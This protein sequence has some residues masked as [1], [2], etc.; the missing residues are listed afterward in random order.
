MFL[1]SA[2]YAA[3]NSN[4]VVSDSVVVGFVHDF[5]KE[6]QTKSEV[7]KQETYMTMLWA[8]ILL[9][10]ICIVLSL[11][12]GRNIHRR[13]KVERENNELSRQ[14]T[15]LSDSYYENIKIST[16]QGMHLFNSLMQTYYQGQPERI[17]PTLE[18]IMNNLVSDEKVITQF[19]E[20]INKTR[21]NLISRLTVS[22]PNLS[23]KEILLYIYLAVQL[24]HNAICLILDKSPGALNAQIY[25]MR[26]KIEDS[27]SPWKEEFLDAI[28]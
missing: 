14:L 19:M 18:S 13:K 20:T 26:R 11:L 23:Q 3:D 9:I 2:Y 24:N 1:F 8:F 27:E 5:R 6:L 28:T 22:V 4:P 25:R 10:Q 16:N 17:V 15:A 7:I 12:T 21:N